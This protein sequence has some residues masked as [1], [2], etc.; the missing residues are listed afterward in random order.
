VNY[1][2]AFR[3]AGLDV[4]A[5]PP[6]EAGAKIR[7]RPS[8]VAVTLA[9]AL[10]DWAAVRR[11]LLG[12]RPGAEKLAQVARDADLDR[13]RDGLRTALD[14][15]D[16]SKRLDALRELARA[17]KIDELA[18]VSLNLLESALLDAGDPQAADGVLRPAQ[19]RYPG[20]VWLNYNLAQCLERLALRE[21]AI[22]Y[23]TAARSIRPETANEL[24]HALHAKGESD[25]AIAVFRHLER[26]RPKN[27]RHL[28]CLGAELKVQG[29]S[30]EAAGVLEAAVALLTEA[31]RTRPDDF[32][33]HF[34]LA[35]ALDKQGK[36]DEAIAE[37]RIALR[38]RP[39]DTTILR[40][41]STA[42][43]EQGKLEEAIALSR[44]AIRL[45]PDARAHATLA[46][47]LS[48]QGKLEQAIAEYRAA[49]RLQP[50]IHQYHENV[51]WALARQGKLEEA[52]AEYHTAIRIDAACYN[53]HTSLG[54]AL[55]RQGKLKEAIAEYK[56]AVR[57][58]PD[59]AYVHNVWAW[60]LV[61]PP[62]RPRRDYDEALEHSR[63]AVALSPTEA[64][65]Q[66][67]LAL[68][69]YRAGHWAESRIASE[70]AIKL[71]E[72]VDASNWFFLAMATWQQGENDQA[73]TW[74]DQAVAWTKEKA[75][76]NSELRQFWKEAAEL[77]PKP[78]P[79]AAGS[80]STSTPA[81]AKL[82]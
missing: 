72:G 67:T 8:A 75:P 68:A 71:T 2:S 22:R 29:R 77:L 4:T 60:A 62:D 44:E 21:E 7:A 74:F 12:D 35:R 18:P 73:R 57:L 64:N 48:A 80:G 41:L 10:D 76:E 51:G 61:L 3:E 79:D 66:N 40:N 56:E 31:S 37:Y 30:K 59:Y 16:K 38:L 19:R 17:A 49:I 39:E 63:K 5:M 47:A 6:G 65:F 52:I 13:W 53:A 70:Q 42:L 81:A 14:F 11:D 1:A 27:T 24:A 32:L 54:D 82:H 26:L 15:G 33:I 9:A 50:D 55:I 25:E 69:E 23:Y 36:P 46:E 28:I 78:G 45:R 20:D 58:K 34:D 43:A